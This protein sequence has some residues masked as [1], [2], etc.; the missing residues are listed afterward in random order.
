MATV[1]AQHI[2]DE[3]S[4]ALNDDTHV[5]WTEDDVL[6]YISAGQ[7]EIVL[8]RPSARSE[9]SVVTLAS[10]TKQTIPASAL[11][12]I[13]VVRNMGANGSTPGRAPRRIDREIMDA[14]RPDWHAETEDGVV[15]NWSFDNRDPTTFYVSP[16]QPAVSPHQ[17]EIMYS[18]A[19]AAVT[20]AS[21]VIDV[22]DA[23][24][25]ALFYY[26]MFRA[27]SKNASGGD[28]NQSGTWYAAFLQA[29]GARK[30][31]AS[32]LHPTQQAERADDTR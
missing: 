17:L 10:G 4:R 15:L 3:V 12:L 11:T 26:S 7:R 13:D 1:T 6:T 18:M 30:M 23:Y 27:L 14:T 19:P 25:P 5:R 9:T 8:I 29:L 16:P 21:D 20:A 22:D 2:I 24:A 28:R 31:A 32:E